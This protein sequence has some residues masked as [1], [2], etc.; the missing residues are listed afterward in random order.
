MAPQAATPAPLTSTARP[1]RRK[2]RGS[3][4]GAVLGSRGGR[5]LGAGAGRG[6]DSGGRKAS[7]T[8]AASGGTRAD[9][10]TSTTRDSSR[11]LSCSLV[12]GAHTPRF[13]SGA[14]GVAPTRSANVY[15]ASVG[16]TRT[17]N[18]G[19]A[20]S[21]RARTPRVHSFAPRA[22]SRNGSNETS[23]SRKADASTTTAA[24]SNT[25]AAGCNP[26]CSINQDD[27]AH[28]CTRGYLSHASR[29][30]PIPSSSLGCPSAHCLGRGDR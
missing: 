3:I 18:T 26:R 23:A 11:V 27:V 10:A 30:H 19:S 6:T 17:H 9:R 24:R 16:R 15:P 29:P 22:S 8:A 12:Q 25:G 14:S 20:G 21:R 5:T 2:V 28:V 7:A 13:R 1:A 4:D